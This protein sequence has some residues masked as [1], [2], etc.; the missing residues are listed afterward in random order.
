MSRLHELKYWRFAGFICVSLILALSLAAIGCSDSGGSIATEGGTV[1]QPIDSITVTGEGEVKAGPDEATL[2]IMVQTEAPEAAAALEENSKQMNQVLE[3]LK[4][5]GLDEEALQTSNVAV[6]P[7]RRWDPQTNTES[8]VGYLAQNTIRV[9]LTDLTKVGDVFSAAA[10]AG[11]NNISGPEWRL[12][13]DSSAIGE[14]LNK[15][16]ASA[17]AK[18]ETLAT[19]AGMKVG[20]VL[21]MQESA[22]T[23]PP[24]IYESRS[25]DM[26]VAQALTEA[27]VNPMDLDVRANVTITFRMTK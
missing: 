24:V 21:T 6:Y 5:E 16:Y 20:D 15:A 17:R 2:T 9:T 4:A 10:E 23:V 27:P 12:A 19:A 1:T 26:A 3:R 25:A 13:D 11:A 22:A 7:N 18:A 14:A 8:T